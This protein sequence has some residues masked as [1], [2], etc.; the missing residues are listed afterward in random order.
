VAAA[1]EHMD[2]TASALFLA[3][4]LKEET[5]LKLVAGTKRLQDYDIPG[6]EMQL[7]PNKMAAIDDSLFH[8]H[9]LYINKERLPDNKTAK[10]K[11]HLFSV[12]IGDLLW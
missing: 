9:S 8:V 12:F 6:V 10:K 4:I 5:A 1:L 2:P 11:F 7:F 3:K